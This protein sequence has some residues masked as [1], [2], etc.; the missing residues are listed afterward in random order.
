MRV[1]ELLGNPPIDALEARLLLGHVTGLSRTE[2]ITQSHRNL[3]PD[4][5]DRYRALLCRRMDGEPIAYLL[6][7]REFYGRMFRVTSDVLIPRPETELLVD[8]AL[9]RIDALTGATSDA[10]GAGGIKQARVLD[11]GTGSGALGV[12]LACERPAADVLVTDI[13]AKALA[14]ASGN[15]RQLGVTVDARI[16]D[17]Y[18]ALRGE[19]FHVIVSNPPYIAQ[20]DP[21]LAQGDLR[22]EPRAAL[23]SGTDGL[24]ALRTIVAGAPDHLEPGGWLLVEHGYDQAPAVRELLHAAGFTQIASWRDLAGIERVSGGIPHGRPDEPGP[25]GPAEPRGPGLD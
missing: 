21:H 1:A 8:L 15:A 5:L 11:L 4:H 23:Q 13:S 19:Q 3:P 14:V 12:T 9:E 16:S 7:E 22:F 20:G 2:L 10:G 6:G 17:W 24:D 25:A 18:D